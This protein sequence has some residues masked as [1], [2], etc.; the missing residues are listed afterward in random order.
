MHKFKT[1]R[2]FTLISHIRVI[3]LNK[4]VNHINES[5]GCNAII[6]SADGHCKSNIENF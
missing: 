1:Q 3:Y 5:D 4:E 6:P 2:V